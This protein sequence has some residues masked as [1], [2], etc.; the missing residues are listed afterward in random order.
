MITEEVE[1][2]ENVPV[3]VS[4][5][6]PINVPVKGGQ[7]GNQIGGQITLSERQIEILDIIKA[8]PSITRNELAQMLGINESAVQKHL[9][10]L[11]LKGVITRI[12]KTRGYWKVN[13]V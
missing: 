2:T 1:T 7:I 3:N 13:D 12:E 11:K 4:V 10:N 8:K 5:N 9:V 6:V